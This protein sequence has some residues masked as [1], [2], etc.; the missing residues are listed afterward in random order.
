MVI[1][2]GFFDGVHLGHRAVISALC[3]V[4]RD[5]GEESMV[6]TFW[7]HPRMVLQ[8]DAE[9][10]RL[11]TSLSEKK[12][13][14]YGLGVGRVEVLD[15]TQEFSRLT[16]GEFMKEY[17]MDRY[18]CTALILGYDHRLGGGPA[19]SREGLERLAGSLGME[20]FRMGEE[21][22]DGVAISSTVIRN[23]LRE[24]D[25]AKANEML[26]YRYGLHGVVVSGNKIGRGI[27]FP[28]AN[29]ELYEP[30]KLLPADGVYAVEADVS[31]RTY[32][33]MTN[34]GTR[35]TV[36]A[37]SKRTVETNIFGFS[38]D[39]YGLDMKLRFVSRIRGEI[40]FDTVGGL[41]RR[42][43]DDK[44]AAERIFNING[45]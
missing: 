11:L 19:M 1:A 40:R 45:K 36:S 42:L 29:M 20:T 43:I 21:D 15:F 9:A 33:G 25:V 39:I 32:Y 4:A 38:S 17:L 34:I 28:T 23:L 30:L 16:A 2:T 37:L 14:L 24:G 27:G 22:F 12:E 35:P 5:R 10:L 6:V 41:Q 26:G 13:M 3:D 18:G 31:G 44:A 7:P 8:Q